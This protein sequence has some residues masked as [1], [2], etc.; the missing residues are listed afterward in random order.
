MDTLNLKRK[1]IKCLCR[2]FLHL[3]TNIIK[4]V[5]NYLKEMSAATEE[6]INRRVYS[7]LKVSKKCIHVVC[8]IMIR[9]TQ[10]FD[11]VINFRST[12]NA[13]YRLTKHLTVCN[14]NSV[15]TR[16]DLST[17]TSTEPEEEKDATRK[18][19]DALSAKKNSRQEL[20]KKSEIRQDGVEGHT[21]IG[22]YYR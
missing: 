10:L 15:E 21:A 4:V 3:A 19:G 13:Y 8:S 1:A 5:S 12:C 20:E 7:L 16:S 18:C 14:S 2:Y 22:R 9:Y 6:L 17:Q 11:G